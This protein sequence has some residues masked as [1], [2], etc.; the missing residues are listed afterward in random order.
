MTA[1]GINKYYRYILP[2]ILDARI[3]GLMTFTLY[4]LLYI[5]P[6]ETR[7][8]FVPDEARYAEISREMVDSGEWLKLRL[9]GLPYYEK[10]PL[11]YWLNAL[12][13]SAFGRT[14]FAVRLPSALS[15][16]L[17][18]LAVFL[19]AELILGKLENGRPAAVIVRA[20]TYP[21]LEHALRGV[22]PDDIRRQSRFVWV[23]YT[24]DNE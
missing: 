15:A 19:A 7:P 17:S 3:L 14:A 5:A 22:Q 13:V 12:S 18:A 10:P 24:S 8:L 21:M 2:R 16:G 11:G 23:L 9:A 1:S 4:I 6:L 20:S